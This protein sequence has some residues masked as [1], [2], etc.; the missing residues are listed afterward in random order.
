MERKPEPGVCP[1]L[2]VC[3]MMVLIKQKVVLMMWRICQRRLLKKYCLT[4]VHQGFLLKITRCIL[5]VRIS[6]LRR[7]D[8]SRCLFSSRRIAWGHGCWCCAVASASAT[9]KG[10][11]FLTLEDETD[12]VNVVVPKAVWQRCDFKDRQA[13]VLM[14]KGRV[15]RRK[16]QA[17][18]GKAAGSLNLG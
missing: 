9:A 18:F 5:F 15:Q 2:K 10:L 16:I 11:I 7:L 6:A 4:I 12:I 14:V 13:S 1:C 17:S 8:C 3:L